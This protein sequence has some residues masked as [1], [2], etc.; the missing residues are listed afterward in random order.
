MRGALRILAF[1]ATAFP[2]GTAVALDAAAIEGAACIALGNAMSA[3][4][5]PF[6]G[7][8]DPVA[9][10]RDRLMFAELADKTRGAASE[11]EFAAEVERATAKIFPVAVAFYASAANVSDINDAPGTV[12]SDRHSACMSLFDRVGLESA[13]K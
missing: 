10:E 2:A 13:Q 11:A 1:V 5:I 12:I 7:P 4:A 6:Y 9:A 8:S 3:A